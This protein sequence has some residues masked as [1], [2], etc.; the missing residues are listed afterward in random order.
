MQQ[1]NK[2]GR[3]LEGTGQLST[4]ALSRVKSM[5]Q[6][7]ELGHYLEGTGELATTGGK[8]ARVQAFLLPVSFSGASHR[9]LSKT[10]RL[11]AASAAPAIT[12]PE[13]PLPKITTMLDCEV[14]YAQPIVSNW[15]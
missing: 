2:L 12:Q 14:Y 1:Q 11:P 13:M 5:Q 4:I 7:N 6:Q 15:F 10:H 9:L 3:Y 8:V